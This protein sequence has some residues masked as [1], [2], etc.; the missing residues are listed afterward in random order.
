MSL[1][2][3]RNN[4]RNERSRLKAPKPLFRTKLGRLYVGKCEELLQTPLLA[5][6]EGKVDLIFTSPPFPLND[7][8][9]YGNLQGAQYL[10]WLATFAHT[11]AKLLAP[12]GSMVMEIG[13]AWG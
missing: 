13:N 9:R 7:K 11:F 12:R 10:H 4:K 1:R 6:L 2:K 3:S 8:K 5:E